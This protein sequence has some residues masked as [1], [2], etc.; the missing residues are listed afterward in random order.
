MQIVC[1]IAGMEAKSKS[2]IVKALGG[3]SRA[4]S[5]L[6]LTY[7]AVAHWKEVPLAHVPAIAKLTGLTPHQIRPDLFDAQERA[8]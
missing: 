3:I 2:E 7:S 8:L 5:A 4:A 1:I 6:G